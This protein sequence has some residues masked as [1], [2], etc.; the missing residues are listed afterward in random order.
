MTNTRTPI[1]ALSIAL[2]LAGCGG[3]SDPAPGC[4]PRAVTVGLYG[5]STQDGATRDTPSSDPYRVVDN[6]AAVIQRAM[7]ARF[8][9]GAVVVTAKA[10]W[11][12][13]LDQLLAGNEGSLWGTYGAAWPAG[14]S[15]DIALENFGVNDARLGVTPAAFGAELRAMNAARAVV[16]E[17]PLPTSAGDG[18][19]QT[20]RDTA[21]ALGAPLIDVNAYA[22]A[23]P[24][25]F[26][27]VPDGIHPN[28]AGYVAITNGVVVPALA[29]MVAPLRCEK[30]P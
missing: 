6:P 26:G 1:L 4:T 24:N 29:A 8:G 17:T 18:L 7:D 21:A 5:D 14:A 23:L 9:A 20:V 25:Y 3:G 13:T 10:I 22:N 30:T 28:D 16:M 19:A 15:E 27:F 11:G 2:S 12:T